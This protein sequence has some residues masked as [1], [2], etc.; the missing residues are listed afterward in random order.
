MRRSAFTLVELLVVIAIIGVLV[1]MLLPAVQAAREAARRSQ[2]S[3]NLKQI[4]IATHNH[5]DSLKVLP[6]AGWDWTA[7]PTY[8]NGVPGVPPNQDAAWGFQILPY[9][10]QGNVFQSQGATDVD[11]SRFAM[12]QPIGVYNC[13][14]RRSKSKIFRFGQ[15]CNMLIPDATRNPPYRRQDLSSQ[16]GEFDHTMCDYV[17]STMDEHEDWRR[18]QS[19]SNTRYVDAR[20]GRGHGPLVRTDAADR[21]SLNVIGFE[22]LKDGS[23][24]IILV[25]EKRLPPNEYD[26]QVWNNDAGYYNAW[27]G[28]TMLKAFRGGQPY[29]PLAD[30]A[31]DRNTGRPID[32]PC[33]D[34]RV[35]S[36]HPAGVNAV[37]CD[38][39]VKLISYNINFDA[40]VSQLYR[41]DGQVFQSN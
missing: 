11:K 33:C 28:D 22:A 15:P 30:G 23:S 2:C 21:N 39:S 4:G 24:N 25:T 36:A 40:F 6:T 37:M 18:V 7:V 31:I 16:F 32:N 27:D 5:V 41:M 38:G 8:I 35:G 26:N 12:G 10:E 29:P 14:S 20:W 9:I 17:G 13:P 34:S 1:A 19:D 3:N